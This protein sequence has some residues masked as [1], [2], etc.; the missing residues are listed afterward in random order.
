MRAM[1]LVASGFRSSTL[2]HRHQSLGPAEKSHRGSEYCERCRAA[3][4]QPTHYAQGTCLPAPLSCYLVG[5]RGIASL[6]WIHPASETSRS[7]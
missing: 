5:F 4:T 7:K 1:P 3:R 2:L 6:L